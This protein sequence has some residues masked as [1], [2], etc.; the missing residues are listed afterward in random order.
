M[1]STFCRRCVSRPVFNSSP[2]CGEGRP[3]QCGEGRPNQQPPAHTASP[4]HADPCLPYEFAVGGRL[5]PPG[6]EWPNASASRAQIPRESST[7]AT[8]R[9]PRG[10][11]SVSAPKQDGHAITPGASTACTAACVILLSLSHQSPTTAELIASCHSQ[12]CPSGCLG[13]SG[14]PRTCRN[15]TQQP[16]DKPAPKRFKAFTGSGNSLGGAPANSTA[17]SETPVQNAS[18][19]RAVPAS[20]QR[21]AV[22]DEPAHA[23]KEDEPISNPVTHS[24]EPSAQGS[25]EPISNP[26]THSN[27]PPAQG[28]EWICVACTYV[29]TNVHAPVCEVCQTER[30]S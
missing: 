1:S 17:L 3:N 5:R 8:A 28:S 12:S 13:D 7:A 4:P 6:R 24:T 23:L 15:P 26:V 20:Q 2:T 21:E 22:N 25:E 10:A 14:F 11:A 29:N 9:I 16:Q 27:E 30:N 18:S 19:D